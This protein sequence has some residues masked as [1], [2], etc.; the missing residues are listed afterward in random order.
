[1]H[2]SKPMTKNGKHRE[3]R[4]M[5]HRDRRKNRGSLW[6]IRSRRGTFLLPLPADPAGGLGVGQACAGWRRSEWYKIRSMID[7]ISQEPSK[8]AHDFSKIHPDQPC[9]LVIFCIFCLR[10]RCKRK[11]L[12]IFPWKY[13]I[14]SVD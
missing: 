7:C 10:L 11:L 3:R 1:M 12:L 13:A 14:I 6:G 4:S 5:Q 8:L 2:Q 9:F